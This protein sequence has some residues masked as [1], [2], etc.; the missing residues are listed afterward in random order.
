MLTLFLLSVA[1]I[2]G[3]VLVS[4]ADPSVRRI[5]WSWAIP[6][7]V[8]S[9]GGICVAGGLLHPVMAY[10][11]AKLFIVEIFVTLWVWWILRHVT[12]TGPRI[13]TRFFL[14]AAAALLLDS[15]IVYLRQGWHFEGFFLGAAPGYFRMPFHEDMMRN[16]S[17]VTALMR[18][19]ESPML[20]GAP[21]TYQTFWFQFPALC[22]SLFRPVSYYPLVLGCSLATGWVFFLMVLYTGFRL[23]PLLF[24]RARFAVPVLLVWLFH[25]DLGNLILSLARTGSLAMEAD[26]SMTHVSYF[27]YLSPKFLSLVGPQHTL[28]LLFFLTALVFR[29]RH[30]KF[31]VGEIAATVFA[32]FAGPILFLMGFPLLWWYTR[33]IEWKR[34]GLTFLVGVAAFGGVYGFP[35]WWI[36]IRPGSTGFSW[37]PDLGW[38]WAASFPLL[39]ALSLG[40][41]G[42][43]LMFTVYRR[44]RACLKEVLPWL[45]FL[46]F[47]NYVVASPEIG[48]HATMVA[49]V[50]A[51]WLL[52]RWARPWAARERGAWLGFATVAVLG[53]LFLIYSYTLKPNLLR[54]DIPWRDYFAMNEVLREQFPGVAVVSTIGTDLGIAKPVVGE[55]ATSFAQAID[56]LTHSRVD[57]ARRGLLKLE[58][59]EKEILPFARQ[60]GYSAVVWGPAEREIWGERAEKRFID[61]KRRLAQVGKVSLYEIH[62][63]ILEE[64]QKQK[65]ADYPTSATVLG[66]RLSEA[67]WRVEAIELYLS[68]LQKDADFAHAHLGLG[69]TLEALGMHR[70]AK[71]HLDRVKRN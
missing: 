48:R 8:F 11:W 19:S 32:L 16:V 60:L 49:M 37:A 65:Y 63:L 15:M 7:A 13:D 55:V 68:A 4:Y 58:D 66:D 70:S 69:R 27:R 35:P 31:V 29:T 34:V 9:L 41:L 59:R 45:G 28:F 23:S 21:L 43:A 30:S 12:E 10:G 57:E 61:P 52:L 18:G 22:V 62:D 44:G 51:G 53:Q 2:G 25:V 14:I 5:G 26:W 20:A 24:A 40:L 46:L 6:A 36:W 3:P 56:A 71:T 50:V 39:P 38:A 54:N 33:P 42:L 17:V 47:F 67:G 64:H 1:L